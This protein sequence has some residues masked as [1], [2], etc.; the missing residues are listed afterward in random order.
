MDSEL[1][2]TVCC[3]VIAFATAYRVGFN[4]INVIL[5]LFTVVLWGLDAPIPQAYTVL[6]MLCL[7]GQS[8]NK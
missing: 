8:W 4:Y 6:G 3:Y 1:A 2:F 5:G 7:I